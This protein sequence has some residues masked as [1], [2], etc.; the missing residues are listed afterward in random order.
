L[1]LL[2]RLSLLTGSGGLVLSGVELG[3]LVVPVVVDLGLGFRAQGGRS[4]L[5]CDAALAATNKAAA[6]RIASCFALKRR[7]HI[8]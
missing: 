7:V 2:S 5:S 8:R 6:V 4:E 3:E 1:G